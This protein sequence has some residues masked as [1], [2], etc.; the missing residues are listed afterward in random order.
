[1]IDPALIPADV[2]RTVPDG[3]VV[4]GMQLPIQSQ[5]TLYVA[6]WE[7]QSG[8][9]ELATIARAADDAGFFYI[10]VCDHTAIPRRL[11]DAMGTIWYDTTATLSWL[12]AQTTRTHLLSHVLVL[13]QRHPLRA[14][15][16]L[17]TLDLLSGGRL[18]VGVGAGHVPEE[19]DLLVG[20]FADRGRHTDEAVS[21]LALAFTTEFPDLPGPRF[22]ASG[23]GVAPR[24]VRQPRPPIWIGGS[25]PA[26]IRRTAVL[27]DG[28]LP[29]GTRRRDLPGQIAQLRELRQE[30]RGGAPIDI[31]TIVE[32]IHLSG[33]GAPWELPGY[34]IAGGAD[35]VATSLRELI[36][37]GVNH[38]QVRFMARS[39]EEFCEQTAA[40][41]AE[42]GPLLNP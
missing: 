25:S 24:P 42:V 28:W 23:L 21:A 32:P 3:K 39:V 20:D 18:I 29:Q 12:A 4:F 33:H 6:D 10:G 37:M 30:H 8:P 35:Q 27:G 11:A 5:S 36:A 15:K 41:G 13:A 40:F 9:A 31:G 14:A 17:S 1:M 16:E 34:V 2:V 38:L 19:Y 22:V 26:A 7:K